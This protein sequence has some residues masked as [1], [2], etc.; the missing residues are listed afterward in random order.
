VTI[1]SP[2]LQ[3][4]IEA[5]PDS[6]AEVVAS[7]PQQKAGERFAILSSGPQVYMQALS[8]PQ[9]FQLEYQEGSIAE[10]YHCTREDLSATV[11]IEVFRDYL[12]GDIFWKR[13]FQFECRDRRTPSYRAGFRVGQLF[14]KLAKYVGIRN[15]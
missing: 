8:T 13:R 12:A 7:L 6:I 2:H 5:T 14:G 1:K 11:I 15:V 4:P 3:Q 9:G 10:H